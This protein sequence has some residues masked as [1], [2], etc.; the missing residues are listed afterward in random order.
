MTEDDIQEVKLEME[1]ERLEL[2]KFRARL[3]TRFFRANSGVLISA[4]VSLA[5]L[6]VSLGQVW[7]TKIS[8]DKELQVATLQKTLELDV[9][10]RQKQKELALLDE[11][12]KRDWNLSAAKFITD[13]RKNIF[14]GNP[15]EQR[16]FAQIIGTIYPA[17]ISKDFLLRIETASPSASKQAWHEVRNAIENGIPVSA[18]ATVRERTLAVH[19]ADTLQNLNNSLADDSQK[20]A[21][22]RKLQNIV[23]ELEKDKD[24]GPAL[25]AANV[26]SQDTDGA[27][28]R[29]ALIEIRRNAV[30]A[31][32]TELLKKINSAISRN[33]Q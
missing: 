17:E 29:R 23:A 1:R 5:A 26:S 3:D 2:D 10:E 30:L 7:V 19:S 21:A 20:D 22:T 11:Q 12:K 6:I 4:A 33:G 24:V 31:N 25:K 16:L 14:A 32:N 9:Q 13:N 28:L 27:K 15:Q 18:A 8:K